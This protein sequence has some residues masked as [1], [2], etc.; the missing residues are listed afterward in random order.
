MTGRDE[1]ERPMS[2]PAI[3][4]DRVATA[5]DGRTAPLTA[6]AGGIL[7]IVAIAALVFVVIGIAAFTAYWFFAIATLEERVA[8]WIEQREAEGWRIDHGAVTRSGFPTRLRLT[9]TQGSMTAPAGWSWASPQTEI[10]LPVFAGWDGEAAPV[11]VA[12]KGEQRLRLLPAGTVIVARGDRLVAQVTEGGRL[13]TGSFAAD[14]LVVG[15]EGGAPVA[16]GRF[17]ATSAGDPGRQASIDGGSFD[18]SVN[19]QRVVLPPDAAPVLGERIERLSVEARLMGSLGAPPWPEA[20]ARWR[21]EGGTIEVSR[22]GLAYGPLD[23]SGDGTL[24]LDRSGDIIAAFSVTARGLAELLSALAERGTIAPEVAA[25]ARFLLRSPA[26]PAETAG[27]AAGAAKAGGASV[28]VPVSI[29][30]RVVFLGPL[31]IARLPAPPWSLR[32]R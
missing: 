19:A 30:E 11:Q 6:K 7:P 2:D 23:L 8:G 26:G 5:G 14:N 27:G 17:E 12:F 28:T 20:L 4:D 32:G 10:G 18:L 21:E 15:P 22:F 9:L 24:A 29:Q 13:P 3:R 25:G 31:P 16:I 1:R